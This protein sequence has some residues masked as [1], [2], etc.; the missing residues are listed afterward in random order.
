MD[1]VNKKNK[2]TGVEN[3]ERNNDVKNRKLE[4]KNG[5]NDKV[6]VSLKHTN[7]INKKVS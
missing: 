4:L 5:V 7:C 6:P 2:H 3:F 1:G